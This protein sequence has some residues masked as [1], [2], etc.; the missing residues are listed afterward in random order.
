[1]KKL[2]LTLSLV[3]GLAMTGFAGNESNEF[4]APQENK[5]NLTEALVLWFPNRVLDLLDIFSVN[6]GVGPIVEARLMATR[7]IDVGAGVGMAYK[8]YKGFH[9][10]YAIGQEQ[11]FYYSFISVG[12]EDWGIVDGTRLLKKYTETRTGVPLPTMRNYNFCEGARDYWQIGGSLGLVLTGDLYIHPLEWLDLAAGI[13]CL[14]PNGDDLRF[15][16]FR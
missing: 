8:A 15:D 10:Q 9:R 2:F 7:A 14:D 6:I 12:E 13:F 4:S 5:F 1:M 3:C 11:G 16:D